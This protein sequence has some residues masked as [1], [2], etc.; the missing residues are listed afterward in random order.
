[1]F[2]WWPY[3]TIFHITLVSWWLGLSQSVIARDEMKEEKTVLHQEGK[4]EEEEEAP[5]V[6]NGGTD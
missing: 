1:M 5:R 3:D 2:I 4:K 6:L